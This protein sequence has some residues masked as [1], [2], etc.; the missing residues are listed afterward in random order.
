MTGMEHPIFSL[1]TKPDMKPRRYERGE[2]WIE[3]SPSRY[4]MATVH[5]RDV[6]IYCISQCMAALN[7]GNQVA[8]K[9]RFKAHDL[10]IA[11]N[12][13]SSGRGYEL[14]RDALRRLQGTQIETNIRQGGREY[15]KVFGL[16]EAAEIVKETRDG[17][18]LDVEITLSDWVFDAIE[19]N[20]VLTLSRQYFF[21]RKPLERRLYELARKHCGA[22]PKWTI[23]LELLRDKCGSSS[24]PKEFRRLVGRII[25]DDANHGHMPDY[26]FAIEGDL[27]AVRPKRPVLPNAP[28]LEADTH[29]IARSF[30]PGWDVRVLEAEWRDWVALK[31]IT[32]KDADRHFLSFCKRR[33]PLR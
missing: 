1:S 17:R 15:F 21:L 13:Q 29:E 7:E 11:T 26:A 14:L 6:L 18:M 32:V 12:R 5:D 2:N 9:M 20:H 4:G 22:Q 10:L 31:G 24:T 33:G 16:I 30:A 19:N 27:L 28:S 25:E 8:R 3:I 23:S